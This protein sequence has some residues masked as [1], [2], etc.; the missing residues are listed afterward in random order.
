MSQDQTFDA[1]NKGLPRDIRRR[2]GEGRMK[3]VSL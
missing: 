3:C 1:S 2:N